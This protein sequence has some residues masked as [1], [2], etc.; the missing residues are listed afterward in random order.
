M[1]TLTAPV[2]HPSRGRTVGSASR[3]AAR[4][5]LTTTGSPAHRAAAPRP[6]RDRFVD[7]VRA[8]STLAVVSVHWLMPEATWDGSHVHAG[9][10]LS[11]GAAWTVTWVLQLLGVLFFASGAAAGYQ[12][13][14][15]ATARSAEAWWRLPARSL[16][17]V[18]LPVVT[19]VGA[20][21]VAAAVLPRLGVP[22]GA[23]G[24]A[25][26]LAPQLMW[27]LGVWMVLLALTALLR[28]AWDRFGWWTVAVAAALPVM[29]DV[30]R[31]AGLPRTLGLD[32]AAVPDAGWANVL[33]VWL[34]PYLL[35]IAYS[36]RALDGRGSRRARTVLWCATVGGFATTALLVALGPYPASM[37]GMPGAAI[38]NLAPPTV[39]ALT[40]AFGQIGALLLARDALLRATRPGTRGAAAVAWVA[41]R[42][43]TLY[44]WHLT[45]MIA[46]VGV[47]VVGMHAVLPEAWSGGWWLT[48][49]AWML[50]CVGVLGLL[51]RCFGRFER[52]RSAQRL[53]SQT[54]SFATG[55]SGGQ[56]GRRTGSATRV[57]AVK[58]TNGS[59]PAIR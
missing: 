17:R 34:V 5:S 41:E 18:L 10:A 42:S 39:V 45:A 29:V 13:R 51:V 52:P 26:H 8:L 43:M 14:R 15:A 7:V 50:A 30:V 6:Q 2:L 48:R 20:W 54:G 49:P 31:F 24:F 21:T 44:L 53:P 9:N 58:T 32:V 36:D 56:D 22:P 33:L 40:L 23:V 11:H 19:F 3:R 16:R 37:I 57:R 38:S 25:V 47:V 28:R 4:S 1:T 12:N 35:G 27:F 55:T 46:V 59:T